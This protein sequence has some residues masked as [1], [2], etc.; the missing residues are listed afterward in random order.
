V[1]EAVLVLAFALE[2]VEIQRRAP[3]GDANAAEALLP[4]LESELEGK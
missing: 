2:E 4:A 3:K 1:A